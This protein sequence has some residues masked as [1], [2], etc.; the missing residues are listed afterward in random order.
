MVI[1]T[2]TK[3][4]SNTQ[5]IKWTTSKCNSQQ[6]L[7]ISRFQFVE[8]CTQPIVLHTTFLKKLKCL[9]VDDGLNVILCLIYSSHINMYSQ[10]TSFLQ[11]FFIVCHI[12]SENHSENDDTRPV[13]T[14]RCTFAYIFYWQKNFYAKYKIFETFQIILSEFLVI[15]PEID[16]LSTPINRFEFKNSNMMNESHENTIISVA[17][18]FSI[19]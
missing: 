14:Y 12:D 7:I 5:I 15:C 19:C 1:I 17:K 2:Y 6:E 13:K 8:L 16:M 9:E 10:N 11:P 18:I 4:Q 3:Q